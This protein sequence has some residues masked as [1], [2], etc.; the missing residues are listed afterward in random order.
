M[1][2]RDQSNL[3]ET[4]FPAALMGL[5][6]AEH[7]LEN[8]FTLAKPEAALSRR[9]NWICSYSY[10]DSKLKKSILNISDN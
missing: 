6:D 4:P 9:G 3:H 2:E 1:T 10:N 5:I 7:I 8:Q